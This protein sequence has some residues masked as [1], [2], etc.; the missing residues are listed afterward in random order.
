MCPKRKRLPAKDSGQ[1]SKQ[2][3]KSRS[4][5]VT[6]PVIDF[7]LLADDIIRKQNIN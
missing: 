4:D 3:K 7:D 2:P 5:D 1:T 6:T